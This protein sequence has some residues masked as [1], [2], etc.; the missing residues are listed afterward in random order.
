M[1][2]VRILTDD[3][4]EISHMPARIISYEA[5]E[6][7]NVNYLS[8]TLKKNQNGKIIYEYEIDVYNVTDESVSEYFCDE[9]D[10]GFKK[11]SEDE[12]IRVNLSDDED[13]CDQS[14]YGASSIHD[15][16]VDDDDEEEVDEYYDES[17][18]DFYDD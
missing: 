9:Y 3:E 1:S 7:F 6:S 10:L 4:G 14:E 2:F 11:I 13:D 16:D 15:D 8:R 17:D 5:N 18:E 12:Y